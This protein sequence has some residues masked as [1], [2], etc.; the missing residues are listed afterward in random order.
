MSD[1]PPEVMAAVGAM[2][3]QL[4]T[5]SAAGSAAERDAQYDVLANMLAQAGCAPAAAPPLPRLP[6]PPEQPAAPAPLDFAEALRATLDA[7]R[8]DLHNPRSPLPQLAERLR[9][10]CHSLASMEQEA[11]LEMAKEAAVSTADTFV[12]LRRA[13]IEDPD[14]ELGI[15]ALV[16]TL[17]ATL[18]GYGE[19]TT[20]FV[21]GDA[22]RLRLHVRP[23]AAGTATRVWSAARLAAWVCETR[24]GGFDVRGQRVLELGCG[25]AAAGLAC[26]ALGAEEV[27]LTDNEPAAL[28]LAQRNA[29][30]N[31][32]AARTRVAHFDLMMPDATLVASCGAQAAAMPSAEAFGC[33]VA[34]DVLYDVTAPA[35]LAATLARLLLARRGEGDGATA[36]PAPRALVVSSRDPTRSEVAQRAVNGF[37]ELCASHPE[38]RVL[39]ELTSTEGVPEGHGD[40]LVLLLDARGAASCDP[41]LSN[42][43]GL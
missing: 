7:L 6:A 11:A 35:Q 36:A 16:G 21:A 29:E 22:V 43:L 33:I 15:A 38:L 2:M 5:I 9:N 37:A 13:A 41:D 4:Q 27:W 12:L 10:A 1:V 25:T 34:S 39:A 18:S 20:T 28:D 17:T 14:E 3:Q 19:H 30:L 26:A 23:Q 32:L 40:V 8:H 42:G 31:G 24:W